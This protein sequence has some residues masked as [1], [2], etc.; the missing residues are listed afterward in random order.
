MSMP[1]EILNYRVIGPLCV[2]LGAPATSYEHM[3]EGLTVVGAE[4]ERQ[5]VL[6]SHMPP[7]LDA[8]AISW[9]HLELPKPD[10]RTPVRRITCEITAGT[11]HVVSAGLALA[12]ARAT[13]IKAVAGPRGS[14][15]VRTMTSQIDA[16]TALGS[17]V[18]AALADVRALA[19]AQPQVIRHIP[20]TAT[21]ETTAN[22]AQTP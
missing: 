19:E 8:N 17:I 12:C 6:G 13:E 3:Q 7:G 2:E 18:D 1:D 14:E 9:A 15:L 16:Y 4:Y 11:L 5:R 22:L 20:H 21:Q 10:S